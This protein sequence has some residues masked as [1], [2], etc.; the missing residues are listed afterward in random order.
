MITREQRKVLR[1][2]VFRH[3]LHVRRG[4]QR[5]N[6]DTSTHEFN[7]GAL[8]AIVL[9]GFKLGYVSEG[10]RQRIIAMLVRSK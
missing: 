10:F 6:T 9:V 2:E 1:G 7:R 5:H 4:T 3:W 8:Y